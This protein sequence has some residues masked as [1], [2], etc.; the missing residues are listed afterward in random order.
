MFQLVKR[1][2]PPSKVFKGQLPFSACAYIFSKIHRPTGL[3]NKERKNEANEGKIINLR[4][5]VVPAVIHFE[6]AVR[7]NDSRA[8]EL[9]VRQSNEK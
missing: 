2:I 5:V 7:Y 8:N 1:V 9:F 3:Q 6:I 4:K